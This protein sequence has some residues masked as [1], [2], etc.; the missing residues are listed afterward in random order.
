MVRHDFHFEDLKV[1]ISCCIPEGRFHNII[2]PVDHDLPSVLRAEDHMVFAVINQVCSA[3]IFRHNSLRNS[4]FI[5]YI[6]Y[7][8][9]LAIWQGTDKKYTHI[10]RVLTKTF[11][12]RASI[13]TLKSGSFLARII[14][15]SL[16]GTL[17]IASNDIL[18]SG[19]MRHKD[20]FQICVS[21]H[22]GQKNTDYLI[23]YELGHLFLHMG[24]KT[25]PDL[26]RNQKNNSFY[27]KDNV[28]KTYEAAQFAFAM[29][30][31][32]AE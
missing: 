19:I 15:R 10:F 1:F 24:Y 22:V 28:E 21:P 25:S 18:E 4:R 6:Y 30:A 13:C 8:I 11:H 26:W 27:I 29:L 31:L 12:C 23:A 2:H 20:N 14:V 17:Y 16:G 9:T 5:F 7:N 3:I 32:F